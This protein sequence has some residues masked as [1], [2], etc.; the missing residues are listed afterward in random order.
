MTYD[1]YDLLRLRGHS[2]RRTKLRVL[3]RRATRRERFYRYYETRLL[4]RHN[5][6]ELDLCFTAP[7]PDASELP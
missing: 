4:G 7:S 1:Y 6:L 2:P 5:R 3:K